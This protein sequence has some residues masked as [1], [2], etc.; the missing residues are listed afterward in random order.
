MCRRIQKD[1]Y[2]SEEKE[3]VLLYPCTKLLCNKCLRH[4]GRVTSVCARKPK[5]SCDFIGIFAL[6][7]CSGAE[8]AIS[9]TYAYILKKYMCIY[10]DLPVN[11]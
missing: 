6:L 11:R 8:P 2:P 5:N 3:T 7:R 4:S 9:L 10:M 1:L